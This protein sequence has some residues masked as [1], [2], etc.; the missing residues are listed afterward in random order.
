VELFLRR[1]VK[2]LI[3]AHLALAAREYTFRKDAIRN[4]AARRRE[5]RGSLP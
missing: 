1:N 5:L 2:A 4:G 3:T